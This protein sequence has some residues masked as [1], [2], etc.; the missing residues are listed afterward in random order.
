MLLVCAR[1]GIL[2]PL[3]PRKNRDVNGEDALRPMRLQTIKQ[4]QRK[5]ETKATGFL[6]SLCGAIQHKHRNGCS[7]ISNIV[8]NISL[9]LLPL[10]IN[11]PSCLCICSSSTLHC[12][13][14]NKSSMC[15]GIFHHAGNTS[16]SNV[17]ALATR[18][19]SLRSLVG[20]RLRR[21]W[22]RA[23]QERCFQTAQG[24]A[25]RSTLRKTQ[26]RRFQES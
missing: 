16:K 14:A 7:C 17:L 24:L 9:K 11:L 23:L 3:C 5:T 13:S 19:F 26:R 8:G 6:E 4:D 15:G 22:P 21:R 12:A 10:A 18:P 20:V 1:A 25:L 2:S